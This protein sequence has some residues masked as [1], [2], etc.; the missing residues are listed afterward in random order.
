M[1]DGWR[2]LR[3]PNGFHSRG[4]SREVSRLKLR[5]VK[6]CYMT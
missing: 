3:D 5:P 4:G 1:R 6:K 2:P